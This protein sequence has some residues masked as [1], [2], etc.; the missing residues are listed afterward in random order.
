MESFRNSF[1]VVLIL[2]KYFLPQV[3]KLPV[4]SNLWY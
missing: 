2:M 4:F 3:C 1:E